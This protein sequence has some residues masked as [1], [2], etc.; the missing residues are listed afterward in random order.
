M[1]SIHAFIGAATIVLSYPAALTVQQLFGGGA[2][3]VIHFV[4]GAGF[5]IFAT[6]VFD[7]S[8]PRWVNVVG[9][10][11]G[12]A[13]GLIFLLQGVSDITQLED[14]RYVAFDVLGHHL[15]RLLPDVVYLWFVA[16][17]LL[18]SE[19]RSRV[20]G[21]VV[22]L[23]VVGLEIA[24]VASLLLGVAMPNVKVIVLL[25]FVWLL[26]ESG[27]SIREHPSLRGMT[28]SL[29]LGARDAR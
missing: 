12:G 10:A 3:T 7:F 13:F 5:I 25:P 6:S 27:E 14:L 4:T 21:W 15:E 2:V 20:L 8:L 22:M 11:A 16:L 24:T 9:A 17:L 1:R 29:P 18:S 19:G 28:S 26:F 23:I